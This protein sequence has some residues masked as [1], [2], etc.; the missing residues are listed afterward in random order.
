MVTEGHFFYFN[1]ALVFK[2]LRLSEKILQKEKSFLS[3]SSNFVT[4]ASSLR[5]NH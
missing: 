5:Y 2:Y 4:P 3:Q 1:L